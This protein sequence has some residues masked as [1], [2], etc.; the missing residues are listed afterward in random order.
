M[1]SYTCRCP[2]FAAVTLAPLTALLL[3]VEVTSWGQQAWIDA[4]YWGASSVL[5]CLTLALLGP[6]TATCTAIRRPRQPLDRWRQVLRI[7]ERT[8][9]VVTMVLVL[10]VFAVAGAAAI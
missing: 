2:R 8:L 3:L 4:E 9:F 6:A 5:I 10:T 1:T 7:E